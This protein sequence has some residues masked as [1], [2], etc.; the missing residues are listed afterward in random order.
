MSDRL[1]VLV[2]CISFTKIFVHSWRY[3]FSVIVSIINISILNFKF[4]FR[5]MKMNVMKEISHQCLLCMMIWFIIQVWLLRGK[6]WR[7]CGR[8]CI[9]PVSKLLNSRGLQLTHFKTTNSYW[10][11]E[12]ESTRKCQWGLDER[13]SW[14]VDFT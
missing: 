2:I 9:L 6:R 7:T 1:L 3:I 4:Y 13:A 12:F 10:A 11:A 14:K 5:K 8:W